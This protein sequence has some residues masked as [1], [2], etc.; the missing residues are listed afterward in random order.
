MA[1]YSDEV[2]DVISENESLQSK[3]SGLG[4]VFYNDAQYDGSVIECLLGLNS[5]RRNLTNVSIPFRYPIIAELSHQDLAVEEG[6]VEVGD[7]V[8]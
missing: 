8:M 2:G 4:L 5:L 1:D 7:V 6:T 3:E